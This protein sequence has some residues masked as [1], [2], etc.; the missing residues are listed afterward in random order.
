M[1]SIRTQPKSR[2]EDCLG[3]LTGVRDLVGLV[4]LPKNVSGPSKDS[5]ATHANQGQTSSTTPGSS[6]PSGQEYFEP[7]PGPPPGHRND[8][9]PP[10]HDWTVVP[11]T[12]LLPPPPSIRY[13]SSTTG[14]APEEMADLAHA[15]CDARPLFT[16]SKPHERLYNS[17]Q[18]GDIELVRPPEFSGDI[19]RKK[20]GT[21]RGKTRAASMDCIL[22]TR[23][24]LYFAAQDSPLYTETSRTVYFEVKI[25]HVGRGRDGD[26]A[27][28]AMGFCAQP[29]PSWRLPG[30]ERGS[31]GVHGDDGRRYVNDSWGGKGFTAP[32]NASETVGIGIRFLVPQN[33]G[34][35]VNVQGYVFFTRG[36]EK[37]GEWNLQE[38][39]DVNS[40]EINGLEGD[41]DLY[42]GVG[43]FG[44]VE[45]EVNFA[46]ARWLYH[47]E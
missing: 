25:L 21:W 8:N 6:G 5:Q 9:P 36:G 10:Y 34:D 39:L 18:R 43:I 22:L 38:E 31:L 28:L 26:Q 12:A 46:P 47:L 15:W 23:L 44:E 37:V 30:W 20:D 17:V 19:T 14:N 13:D 42:G 27:S 4:N 16:P 7:P 11:D 24:P 29:Y 1:I 40:G 41:Y 3:T 35:S 32:F 2:K 45:F 33:D